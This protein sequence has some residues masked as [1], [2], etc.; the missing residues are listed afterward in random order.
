MPVASFSSEDAVKTIRIVGGRAWPSSAIYHRTI[1]EFAARRLGVLHCAR[2][3][4][5]Q[6]DFE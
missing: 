3:V 6:T 1:N 4:L 5:A 2:L